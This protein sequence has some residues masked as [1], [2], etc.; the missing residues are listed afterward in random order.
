M[1]A[2]LKAIGGLAFIIW[3]WEPLVWPSLLLLLILMVAAFLRLLVSTE[4]LEQKEIDLTKLKIGDVLLFGSNSNFSSF[5]IKIV[6]IITGK[7]S[8][9]YWTHAAIH[10]G[11]GKLMEAIAAGVLDSDIEHYSKGGRLLKV[12]RHKY[13]T[14][15]KFF[16]RLIEFSQKTKDEKYEY[17][18]K[19]LA[20]YVLA[21]S[22]PKIWD[23]LILDNAIVDRLLHLDKAYFCSEFVADAYKE[24]GAPVSASDSWRVKPAD[25]MTNPMFEEVQI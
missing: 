21:I 11:E 2:L 8:S 3:L 20:F 15:S 5:P 10:L 13:I 14:D 19:G 16:D 7:M 12:Y 18:F 23:W 24:C 9:K 6:N 25:F 1:I 4:K 17:D 22:L